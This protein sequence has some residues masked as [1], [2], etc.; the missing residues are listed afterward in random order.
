M[1][2]VFVIICCFVL[3]LSVGSCSS[4]G[5][6]SNSAVKSMVTAEVQDLLVEYLTKKIGKGTVL[7]DVLSK[8][9]A[10]T[11]LSSI[12]KGNGDNTNLLSDLISSKFA[13]SGNSVMKAIT[14]ESSTLGSLAKFIG[15]NSSTPTLS[16]VLGVKL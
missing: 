10:S 2:K 14:G 1:R 9:T 12:L 13:L 15:S 5:V 7:S 6:L 16:D 4:T 11:T 8:A 3:M